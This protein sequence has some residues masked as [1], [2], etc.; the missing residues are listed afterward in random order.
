[1]IEP[2]PTNLTLMHGWV[3]ESIVRAS[4]DGAP[5]FYD[6]MSGV[7][8]M[9]GSAEGALFSHAFSEGY[10]SLH[11]G[12][13]VPWLYVDRY[14]DS[15]WLTLDAIDEPATALQ[16][17]AT[18]D[19]HVLFESQ[20]TGR[21]WRVA[22]GPNTSGETIELP[23]TT[24]M[25]DP[26]EAMSYCTPPPM[27]GS[28]GEVLMIGGSEGIHFQTYDPAGPTWDTLGQPVHQVETT[29][30]FETDGTWILNGV[31][32]TFCPGPVG[33]GDV[34]LSGLSTQV[35][36]PSLGA[37]H[38]IDAWDYASVAEGGSCV[39]YVNEEGIHVLDLL[40]AE[41]KLLGEGGFSWWRD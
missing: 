27:L 41:T 7:T 33:S 5:A 36:S 2:V 21:R 24:P 9:V 28:S 11:E 38:V 18:S 31:V 19:H 25:G 32:G 14:D 17:I 8:T 3:A 4:V 26:P 30:A 29:S 20:D 37:H 40:T 16:R 15:Q 13:T 6:V 22:I 34:G 10:L 1:V 12:K 23:L 35:V 39:G